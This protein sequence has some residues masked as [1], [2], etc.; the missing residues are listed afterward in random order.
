MRPSLDD[1]EGSVEEVAER[2]TEII[3]NAY[4]EREVAYPV[5]FA[6]SRAFPD[7]NT[8]NVFHCQALAEWAN[9]KFR[10]GLKG[11]DLEGRN[12]QQLLDILIPLSRRYTTE[13]GLED[14]VDAH[15]AAGGD[16][17]LASH[18]TFARERFD[19]LLSEGD[20]ENAEPRDVLLDAGAKFLRREITELERFVLLEEF[21]G[22]WKD[23]LLEMDHLKSSI[24]L[25]GY[26]EQDPKIAYKREGSAL[27]RTMLD[28][29]RGRVA[30]NIFKVRLSSSARLA[31]VYQISQMVHEQLAGYDHLSQEMQAQQEATKPQK[32]ETIR[33]VTP[34]VG[35]NDP[36]P[37][38]SGKKYKKCHGREE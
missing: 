25:R 29:V 26:A 27:F 38:G 20:F 19:T 9:A 7:G 33:R 3:L 11:E 37:C 24:G 35:R 12:G 4:K 6:L 1:L 28:T 2:L 36:C 30:E 31:N 22:A 10:A 32:V 17:D 34:K 14:E 15:M 21:D 8:A 13:G 18:I 5:E 23:H 16:G